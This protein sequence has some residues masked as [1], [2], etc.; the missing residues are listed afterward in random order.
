MLKIT[1]DPPIKLEETLL[2]VS[3]LLRCA[4]AAAYETGDQLNG[5][6]RDLA[7]SVMYLI[8]MAQVLVDRSLENVEVVA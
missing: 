4:S 3:D 7:F 5:Q 2:R 6:K 8:E 1:P